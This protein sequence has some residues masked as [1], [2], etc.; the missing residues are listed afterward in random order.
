M[1]SYY[2]DDF[3]NEEQEWD[4][5][6][7]EKNSDEKQKLNNEISNNEI[8]SFNRK[9]ILARQ[10]AYY[11]LH[12]LSQAIG[13]KVKELEMYENGSIIPNNTII[14]KINKILNSK[15]ELNP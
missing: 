12:R 9:L 1:P 15:L 2:N 13:V 3:L 5:I 11:S 14:K 4:E 10:K 8:I 7:W 6:K